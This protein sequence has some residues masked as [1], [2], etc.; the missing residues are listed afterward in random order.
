MLRKIHI[1]RS[2]N[3]LY[4]KLVMAFYLFMFVVFF[5]FVVFS[6][7]G[8]L[9]AA[10][11]GGR[12]EQ[13]RVISIRFR[14]M[15]RKIHIARSKN[16]VYS[17][18]IMA[19]YLFMFV[20]FS[21]AGGLYAAGSGGRQEQSRVISIRTG[22]AYN[23][24]QYTEMVNRF[25]L[26]RGK[27]LNMRIEYTVDNSGY[28]SRIDR[29]LNLFEEPDIFEARVNDIGSW[30]RQNRLLPLTELPD[31]EEILVRASSYNEENI[32]EVNGKIYSL[33]HHRQYYGIA[34]NKRLLARAGFE[35]PPE[36]WAEFEKACIAISA[37]GPGRHFGYAIPLAYEDYSRDYLEFFP[38]PS[39]GY[40]IF[41]PEQNRFRF[42]YLLPLFRMFLRIQKA[43]AMYPGIESLGESAMY[44]QFAEGRI[45]FI[46]VDMRSI[47]RLYDNFPAGMDW[48]VMPF[49]L[50]NKDTQYP[51]AVLNIPAFVV[52]SQIKDR[53]LEKEAAEAYKLISGDETFRLLYREGKDMPLRPD[54][55]ASEPRPVQKQFRSLL[56]LYS[57][58]IAPPLAPQFDYQDTFTEILC[59][60]IEAETALE[61]LEMRLNAALEPR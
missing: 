15:L 40:F 57:L 38:A 2:K 35:K 4:S 11:S 45:G 34:Y 61:D 23:R 30:A 29:A 36:T 12:Q 46:P 52:S 43:G 44:A 20:V 54:I 18:S 32:T 22:M 33:I 39:F 58:T 7:A 5:I 24:E 53:G 13:S 27:E 9:Y 28:Q 48:D 16:R 21:G 26:G 3:R 1:A 51:G 59:G 41:D 10:G 60:R 25:N 56:N 50:L 37:L 55:A 31:L 14:K 8:G 47:G 42:N 19:F 6:G 17:K 49:P